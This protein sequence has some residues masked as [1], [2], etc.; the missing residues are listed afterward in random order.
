MRINHPMVGQVRKLRRFLF[1]PKRIGYQTRW[2]EM[3]MWKEYWRPPIYSARG[4]TGG[5]WEATEWIYQA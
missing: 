4:V 1:F 5:R 3:A 2:F